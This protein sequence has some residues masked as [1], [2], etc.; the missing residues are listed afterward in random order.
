VRKKITPIINK[1]FTIMEK[2]I[3]VKN[4]KN[5]SYKLILKV[6]LDEEDELLLK[7]R[8]N[9]LALSVKLSNEQ[10]EILETLFGYYWYRDCEININKK[11]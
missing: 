5:D 6:E 9:L 2:E 10:T 3:I 8:F 1:N 4:K 11:I 7:K